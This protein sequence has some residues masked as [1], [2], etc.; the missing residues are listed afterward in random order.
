MRDT[1]KFRSM[2]GFSLVELM[3]GVLIGLI[4]VMVIFQVFSVS[5]GIKRTTTGGGDAQQ[6]GSLSLFTIERNLRMAGYGMNVL[7]F[8]G[9]P[10]RFYDEGVNPP[11][12]STDGSWKLVPVEII[13]GAGTLAD[14]I[15]MMRGDSDLTP[16][17]ATMTQ[18]MP[19][20][21]ADYK[22][23]VRYGFRPGDMVL[24]V[25]PGK[26]CTIAQATEIP[27]VKGKSDNVIHNSGTYHDDNGVAHAARYNK[28]AGLGVSYDKGAL[29]YNLGALPGRYVFQIQQNRLT[30]QNTMT[31][32]T[33]SALFDNVVQLQAEYGKDTNADGIVDVWNA[34][35]PAAGSVEWQG[36]IALR[37]GLVAR[38]TTP[39]RPNPATGVCETTTVNPT[40][41][42]PPQP[43]DLSITGADWQCFR[44]KV[45]ETVV[46]LKNLIW[47]PEI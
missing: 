28:P 36:I 46:P 18:G 22:V 38:S 29:L 41:A 16:V 9:C 31:E 30:L 8:I 20:P 34:V 44:Y 43:I 17:P 6:N 25:E 21:S 7:N 23:D 5:E 12:E 4:G 32:A 45:F 14:T 13:S 39:E 27:G 26:D 2:A 35:S 40:W 11:F 15:I 37:M 1:I 3:V 19:S 10:I 47:R 42:D 24:A 33:S